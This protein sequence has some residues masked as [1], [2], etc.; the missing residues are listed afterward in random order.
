[1][2]AKI[3]LT[4]A[5]LAVVLE[6]AAANLEAGGDKKGARSVRQAAKILRKEKAE[7]AERRRVNKKKQ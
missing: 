1:M 7:R 3:R 4:D 2:G 6:Q 5:E